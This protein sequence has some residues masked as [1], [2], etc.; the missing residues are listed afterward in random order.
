M[1]IFLG[2]NVN[3]AISQTEKSFQTQK[4]FEAYVKDVLL[5]E[6]DAKGVIRD[7]NNPIL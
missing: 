4:S 5:P 2:N 6:L 7:E 3:Y 1:R